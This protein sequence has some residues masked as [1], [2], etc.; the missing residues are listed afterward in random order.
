MFATPENMFQTPYGKFQAHNSIQEV[1][2]AQI[3]AGFRPLTGIFKLTTYPYYTAKKAKSASK[4]RFF[5]VTGLLCGHFLLAARH[6]SAKMRD[7]L[8]DQTL[9]LFGNQIL[10]PY[11]FLWLVN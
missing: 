3:K 7:L 8:T 1:R 10:A 11:Q 9:H 4:C 6:F 5:G 2:Q